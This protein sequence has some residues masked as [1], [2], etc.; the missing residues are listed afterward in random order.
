MRGSKLRDLYR[1]VCMYVCVYCR[2]GIIPN[3]CI[4]N[5]CVAMCDDDDDNDDDK[6]KRDK[7]YQLLGNQPL[8]PGVL[9]NS[10]SAKVPHFN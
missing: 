10:K 5:K 4:T 7:K 2:H 3:L 1:Y 6:S 9:T 8:G